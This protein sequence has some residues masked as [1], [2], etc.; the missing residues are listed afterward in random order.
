MRTKAGS[1]EGV[2]LFLVPLSAY[3]HV[4]TLTH[5]LTMAG[6]LHVFLQ[7]TPSPWGPGQVSTEQGDLGL[8][9]K[10]WTALHSELPPAVCGFC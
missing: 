8:A 7:G 10:V 3:A 6:P 1:S 2:W 4:H 9:N 5:P